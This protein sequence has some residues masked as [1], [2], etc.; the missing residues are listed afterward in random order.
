MGPIK[1]KIFL[2]LIFLTSLL[3]VVHHYFS[4]SLVPPIHDASSCI[5]RSANLAL[6][7]ER[8]N[9][10]EYWSWLLRDLNN[11]L[12]VIYLSLW[13]L[14]FGPGRVAWGWCWGLTLI[15]FS[16]LAIKIYGP[17]DQDQVLLSILILFG[18]TA[19]LSPEGGL[20]DQRFD[21]LG[22][23]LLAVAALCIIKREFAH[24]LGVTILAIYFKGPAVPIGTSMWLAAL[25]SGH[26]SLG[27]LWISAKA[28]K[29]KYFIFG[30]LLG[31]YLIF[32]IGPVLSY[33]LM[34]LNSGPGGGILQALGRAREALKGGLEFY[35]TEMRHLYPLFIMLV[36]LLAWQFRNQT[37]VIKK[38][39]KF[40]LFFWLITYLLFSL[41][42]IKSRVLLIWFM[43]AVLGLILSAVEMNLSWLRSGK[44][45]GSVFLVGLILLICTSNIQNYRS[46]FEISEA[47]KLDQGYLL[48]MSQSL[49]AVI[50]G[51]KNEV[52]EALLLVNFVFARS[53]KVAFTYDALR[54][55]VIEKM[56][57][58]APTLE[59]WEAGTFSDDWLNEA[60]TFRQ[61]KNF[62]VVVG[63]DPMLK[64]HPAKRGQ[65]ISRDIHKL[66]DEKCLPIKVTGAPHDWLGSVF[67][68][69][70]DNEFSCSAIN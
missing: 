39:I 27:Q 28:N 40:S 60:K 3:V 53:A 44:K 30:L 33:N 13:N 12:S 66:L 64:V 23:I 45:R 19:I 20:L 68:Y 52:D 1:N 34:A 50:R 37:I 31:T 67:I 46:R 56:G 2:S 29:F 22:A 61:H 57:R 21:P 43:P 8:G 9:I 4:L 38:R 41:H 32:F 36:V 6:L 54:V 63:E 15:G 35:Y 14:V 62:F 47:E 70:V 7:L 59:G 48:Q 49:V 42:P 18:T 26:L 65:G 5:S 55:L 16:Y 11:F 17:K 25:L 24:A 69:H 51:S 10:G 58:L